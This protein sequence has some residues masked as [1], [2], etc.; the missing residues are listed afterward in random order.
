MGKAGEKSREW[1]K[2]R[3]E[4]RMEETRVFVNLEVAS[5]VKMSAG[6]GSK[7][8]EKGIDE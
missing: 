6:G 3:S 7:S 5:F 4:R 2:G 1:I 8:S